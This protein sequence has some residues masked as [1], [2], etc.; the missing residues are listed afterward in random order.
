VPSRLALET[1]FPAIS[2]ALEHDGKLLLPRSDLSGK[3]AAGL[4]PAIL[5]LLE[6]RGLEASD[7]DEILVDRGPGSYTGIRIGLATAK[8][9][10]YTTGARLRT[11]LSTDICYLEAKKS[12]R[13]AER[14]AVLLDA[15]RGSW[16]LTVYEGPGRRVA[17]P[18]LRRREELPQAVEECDAILLPGGAQDLPELKER[19]VPLPFPGAATAFELEEE[20]EPDG[21]SAPLYLMPPI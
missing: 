5:E 3:R 20:L 18:A 4:H 14:T 19:I 7:L 6:G 17:P 9:L 13:T 2:V 1:A 12:G 8:T 10:A 16:S 11:F 21:D 15:R